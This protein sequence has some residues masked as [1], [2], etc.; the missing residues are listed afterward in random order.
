MTMPPAA[1]G[2]Q[3][4]VQGLPGAT[5][6]FSRPQ[7][8][9]PVSCSSSSLTASSAQPAPRLFTSWVEIVA[10]HF[11]DTEVSVPFKAWK[12]LGVDSRGS[13]G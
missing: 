2:P 1:E 7:H 3:V 9:V 6:A 8:G 11:T 13:K 10:S 12:G 5:G 4:T